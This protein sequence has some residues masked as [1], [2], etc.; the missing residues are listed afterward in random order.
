MTFDTLFVIFRFSNNISQNC[1]GSGSIFA[2]P[3][4]FVIH[5]FLS[6]NYF[7]RELLKLDQPP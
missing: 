6:N 7:G 5:C 4:G 2:K 1:S 3:L